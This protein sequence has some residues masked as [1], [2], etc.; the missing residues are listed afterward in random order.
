MKALCHE[1]RPSEWQL[2][3]SSQCPKKG[4]KQSSEL[5][6][7]S[8][9][10]GAVVCRVGGVGSFPVSYKERKYKKL[11]SEL[12]YMGSMQDAAAV[13]KRSYLLHNK[14]EPNNQSSELTST[15]GMCSASIHLYHTRRGSAVKGF[16]KW[17][18][19]EVQDAG[20][21]CGKLPLSYKE[22]KH[23]DRF[24]EMTYTGGSKC[25]CVP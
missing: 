11:S 5:A 25:W 21:V 24:S 15:G 1:V 14:Q 10:R 2:P 13:H 3:T 19:Q 4:R 22:R 6:S 9:M 17:L 16:L 8:D 12:P 18:I 23:R 20:A 7:T